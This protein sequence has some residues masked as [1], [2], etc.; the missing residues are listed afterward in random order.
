MLKSRIIN[1]R[2]KILFGYFIVVLSVGLSL[3]M[4][5]ARIESLQQETDFLNSHDLEVH[6][7]TNDIEKWVLDMETAQRGYLLSGDE[8][9]LVPYNNALST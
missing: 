4:V 9:Y 2:T 8:S 3:W 1:I 6:N 5:S 7:L